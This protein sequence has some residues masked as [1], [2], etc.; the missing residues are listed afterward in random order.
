M[1]GNRTLLFVYLLCLVIVPCAQ[2]QE[3]TPAE[4]GPAELTAAVDAQ[5]GVLRLVRLSGTVQ[6]ALGQPRTGV[7]GITFALYAEQEGGAPLWLETQNVELDAEG[8]YAVL[9]GAESSEGLPLEF[10]STGEARWL[11]VTVQG[12]AEQPRILLVSVPYALKAADAERLGGQL[13]SSFVSKDPETGQLQA[14]GE[15]LESAALSGGGEETPAQVVSGTT[16]FLAKFTS[17]TDLGDSVVFESASRIGL[18]TTQPVAKLDVRSGSFPTVRIHE[19]GSNNGAEV[20]LRLRARSLTGAASHADIGLTATATESGS[21]A[22]RI[23]WNQPARMTIRS[24]GSVGI[25]TTNPAGPLH[26]IGGAGGGGSNSGSLILGPTL[27]GPHLRL[28]YQTGAYSWMQS[29]GGLPLRI[30]PLGNHVLLNLSGGNVGIGTATPSEK[31]DVAGTVKATAFVGVKGVGGG[32]PSVL[33]ELRPVGV[34]G[35]NTGSG[36]GVLATNNAA[37]NTLEIQNRTTGSAF[38]IAAFDENGAPKFGVD[39][40]GDLIASGTKSA[41]V[42]LAGGRRVALFAMESPENWFE[43]F[44]TGRLSGGAA[45]VMLDPRFAETVNTAVGYHVFLTPNGECNGLF[46]AE[47]TPSG[48]TVR[49]LGGGESNVPFDYRIVARRK[50]YESTRLPELQV[51][52]QL[53]TPSSIRRLKTQ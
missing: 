11:G 38:L 24:D 46:V 39:M 5:A 26:I 51:G 4:P 35:D 14:G 8:R 40:D 32:G 12:E 1:K 22:F 15:V 50:G 7:L 42:A 2:G 36:P 41:A 33:V 23:P 18:G 21:L 29:H 19:D 9:L 37:E 13:A 27:G 34:W 16:G 6:D 52:V 49:E 17:S 47:K 43:D 28:G 45:T 53:P 10:F 20:G 25:G 48:F 3:F 31:L 44:G 30:N